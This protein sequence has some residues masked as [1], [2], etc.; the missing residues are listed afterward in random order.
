VGSAVLLPVLLGERRR[1]A[2]EAEATM[3]VELG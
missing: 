2:V 3:Q 1:S